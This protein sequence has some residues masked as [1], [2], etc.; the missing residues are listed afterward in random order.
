MAELTSMATKRGGE[1]DELALVAKRQR[2]D[3]GAIVPVGS[4]SSQPNNQL[5]VTV[6]VG[7]GHAHGL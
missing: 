6:E 4:S 1:E 3:G 2:T 5:A 7:C